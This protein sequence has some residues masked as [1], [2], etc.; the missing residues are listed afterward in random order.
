[1]AYDARE[2]DCGGLVS[3]LC[4]QLRDADEVRIDDGSWRHAVAKPT[5][6][7]CCVRK[8]A[9]ESWRSRGDHLGH[10]RTL[11]DDA[12]DNRQQRVI[13]VVGLAHALGEIER[14]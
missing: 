14:A 7:E 9:H 10:L 3:G 12:L 8:G 13:S 11:C 4:R 1:M 2:H 6:P 5:A